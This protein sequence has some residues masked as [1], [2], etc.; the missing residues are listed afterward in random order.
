MGLEGTLNIYL[1]YTNGHREKVFSE[2]N[3]ITN[4]GRMAI[5]HALGNT[6]TSDPITRL[7]A[8]VGGTSDSKGLYPYVENPAA[9]GLVAEVVNVL[10]SNVEDPIKLTITFLA[11]IL[12]T[13]ANGSLI[14]EAGLF[15]AS[16]LMFN[17]KNHPGIFK[18]SA[19]SI[20]Y[21]WVIST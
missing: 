4:N 19:F 17:L 10:T 9:T 7:H 21:E 6:T 18:S 16:G 15:K 2:Q 20:H 11:D 12:T 8:G 13:Q 5:L 1:D 14:T 3:L